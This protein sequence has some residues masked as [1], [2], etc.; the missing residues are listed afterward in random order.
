MKRKG[1][2]ARRIARQRHGWCRGHPPARFRRARHGIAADP[3]QQRGDA[4]RFRGQR[5]AAAG[6]QVQQWRSPAQFDDQ[7]AQCGTAQRIDRSAQQQGIILHHADQQPGRVKPQRRKAGAIRLSHCPLG[8]AQPEQR[9]IPRR[10]MS[11]NQGKTGG[12][13]FI[14][15]TAEQFMQ[16]TAR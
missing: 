14:L 12:G 15:V 10:Q 8:E 16:P 5:Q 4:R 11:E 13:T 7:R 2:H 6:G 9:R 1:A 3:Q